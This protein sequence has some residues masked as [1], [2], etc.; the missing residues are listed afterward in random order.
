MNL[1]RT[2]D[3]VLLPG[4]GPH[5]LQTLVFDSTALLISPSRLLQ[6]PPPTPHPASLERQTAVLYQHGALLLPPSPSLLPLPSG[7]D[8]RHL[9]VPLLFPSFAARVTPALALFSLCPL[10]THCPLFA[11]QLRLHQP[12]PPPPTPPSVLGEQTKLLI[13]SVLQPLV[14]CALIKGAASGPRLR[15]EAREVAGRPGDG[16]GRARRGR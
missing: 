13:I 5:V 12:P 16:G 14:F 2:Y 1:K 4:S 15:A 3:Q 10:L 6:A 11:P 8:T 9:L 7:A